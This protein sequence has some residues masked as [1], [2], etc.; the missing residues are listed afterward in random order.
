MVSFDFAYPQAS[1]R[2]ELARPMVGVGEVCHH[3]CDV[4]WD[5]CGAHVVFGGS[6]S[7]EVSTS[8]VQGFLERGEEAGSMALVEVLLATAS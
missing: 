2:L 7:G 6:W 8:R 1:V 4:R 5:E 3:W